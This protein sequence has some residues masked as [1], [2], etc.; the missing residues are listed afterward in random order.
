V[1]IVVLVILIITFFVSYVLV[2]YVRHV[3]LDR[4]MVDIPN[5]RS[6]HTIPTPR[7]GGIAIVVS[8]VIAV[9]GLLVSHLVTEKIWFA[10]VM[11][12]CL[13]AGV[14]HLDDRHPLRATTR[15]AVHVVAAAF[16]VFMLRGIPPSELSKWGLHGFWLGAGI[17]VLVLVWATNLFNFMDGIDGI[18]GSES[19][20][21]AAAGGWLN[22]LNGGDPGITAM[23]LS[24]SVA[25]LGFLLWN[26]PPASV[27]MG[28]VGSGFLGFVVAALLMFTCLVSKVPIEVLPIL[29]GVFLVDATI[30]L[31][32][33][34]FRGDRWFE[35][36]RTHAYQV[37]A[38]KLGRHRPVTLI[39]MAVNVFWLLP[40]AYASNRFPSN[41][42]LYMIAALLPLVILSIMVG[43]GRREK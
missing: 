15:F 34:I 5:E 39:V 12:G 20:F 27:F 14:G 8:F 32:R 23:L 43:A 7:G 4:N 33:R 35:P 25:S 19:F 10:L 37:L 2:G 30:T 28:D 29:G 41:S 31:L 40:W 17:S 38:K 9:S 16:V 22:W 21:V 3:A 6:S 11:S 18:A 42:R 36:H 26:W 1:N 13:V 24:L